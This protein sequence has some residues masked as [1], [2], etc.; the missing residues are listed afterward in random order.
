MEKLKA[1]VQYAQKK[2]GMKNRKGESEEEVGGFSM[3][4]GSQTKYS[5]LSAR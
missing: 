1:I 4:E 2:F 5:A 3:N